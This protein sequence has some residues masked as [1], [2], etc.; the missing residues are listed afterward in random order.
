[1]LTPADTVSGRRNQE[2]SISLELWL[3]S[4]YGFWNGIVWWLSSF[5]SWSTLMGFCSSPL[6][7]FINLSILSRS[8]NERLERI[9][10]QEDTTV[11]LRW[12]SGYTRVPGNEHAHQL[13]EKATDNETMPMDSVKMKP[14]ALKEGAQATTEVRL[15]GVG[16]AGTAF[17]RT[18]YTLLLTVSAE[19]MRA[20]LPSSCQASCHL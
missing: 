19:S 8:I 1:M 6:I 18:C 15:G 12:V 9:K 2:Q 7:W 20:P 17:H 10:A 16:N 13:A 4:Y 5:A 3:R 11:L 14:F